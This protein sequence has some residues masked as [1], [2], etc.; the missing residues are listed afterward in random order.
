METWKKAEEA[1]G[2]FIRSLYEF[3]E[4]ERIERKKALDA[5]KAINDDRR[6]TEEV[7]QGLANHI[8]G[9][10]TKDMKDNLD[11]NRIY[12]WSWRDVAKELIDYVEKL[13]DV[14]PEYLRLT[15]LLTMNFPDFEERFEP[16]V[17]MGLAVK[18]GHFR[19]LRT[20][21][22]IRTTYHGRSQ[23]ANSSGY[24]SVT[25][26]LKIND[27]LTVQRFQSHHGG[28]DGQMHK[29]RRSYYFIYN[30]EEETIIG[31]VG[32]EKRIFDELNQGGGEVRHGG[33]MVEHHRKILTEFDVPTLKEIEK[34]M[35]KIALAYHFMNHY[36]KW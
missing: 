7:V 6:L 20:R 25:E 5:L 8:C 16:F 26:G 29:S 1:H 24:Q 34:P 36:K 15:E 17:R 22:R 9:V 31:E 19:Q 33:G 11:F 35:Q 27:N 3:F 14:D 18:K 28:M 32:I 2:K 10:R 30:R 23:V 13:P 21:G 4:T 12:C